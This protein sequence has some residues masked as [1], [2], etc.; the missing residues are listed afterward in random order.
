[1]KDFMIRYIKPGWLQLGFG[2]TIKL[3]ATFTDLLIPWVLAYIIDYVTPTGDIQKVVLFGIGM[4]VLAAI[5]LVLNITANRNASSVTMN[6][7]RKLRYDLFQS[8]IHLT[9][10]QADAFTNPSLISRVT[11]D[12]YNVHSTVGMLQRIGVRAPILL[13]GGLVVTLFTDAGLAMVLLALQPIIFL[14]VV[15]ISKMGLPLYKKLQEQLDK[16]VLVMRE[17][18]TGIRIIKALSK[19]EYE[20]ARFDDVNK[21]LTKREKKVANL[22]SMNNPLMSL[23]LNIGLTLVVFIGAYRVQAGTTQ[24]GV[25]IAFLS[26]FTIIINAMFAMS[27][28]FVVS[29]KGI[30]S[31]KRIDEIIKTQPDLKVEAV[32]REDSEYHI[33]FRDVS[34][35]YYKNQNNLTNI[36]FRLKR[37][38]SLGII[39]P[40]GSGKTTIIKLLM[41]FYDVSTGKILIDG[42]DIRSIPL[43]ELYRMFGIVFQDD[44]LF[45]D[46][47]AENISLGRS[48]PEDNMRNSVEM[49][50]A[51]EFVYSFDNQLNHMLAI[52]GANLSGGQKQRILI[53]RALAANPEILILDDSSSALDYATDK[54]LRASISTNLSK[55]TTIVV[56]QRI[57]S[58]MHSDLIIVMEN[59]YISGIGS[60]EELLRNNELYRKTSEIQLKA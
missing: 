49:A 48:I 16:I 44:V 30:A 24:I 1:M 9:H 35:S 20:K 39:G 17:N 42:R 51:D 19:T 15:L 22:M 46:T 45:A 54:K 28:I 37:G 6:I 41:R 38:E 57:S 55:S 13:I 50:Q 29:T 43:E 25:I 10:A 59:G 5:G 32:P 18:I 8:I 52:R 7:T 31:Y 34:F 2:L 60:H 3:I 47:I 27:R 58:I 4:I 12:T 11:S 23:Y 26:Y 21:E 14:T 40:T 33:E 36:S 53:S 56:A